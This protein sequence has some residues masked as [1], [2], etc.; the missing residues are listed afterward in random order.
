MK[1]QALS[2]RSNYWDARDVGIKSQRI[3]AMQVLF[4]IDLEFEIVRRR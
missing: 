4:T 1:S 3:L 2:F